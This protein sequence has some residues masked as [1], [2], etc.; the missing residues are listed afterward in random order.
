MRDCAHVADA[1]GSTW[2]ID[3]TLDWW[4]KSFDQAW[5]SMKRILEQKTYPRYGHSRSGTWPEPLSNEDSWRRWRD[6]AIAVLEN[7]YSNEI[8]N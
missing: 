8:S 7:E 5:V 3:C 1:G 2:Y 6:E 4:Y